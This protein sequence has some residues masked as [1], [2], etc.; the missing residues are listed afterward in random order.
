MSE[1]HEEAHTGPV[2]T[3]TQFLMMMVLSFIIPVFVII[4]LVYYI[5]S[6]HKPALGVS[7]PEEAIASRIQKV[8][9]VQIK[10]ANQPL[11]TGEA[12][13]AAQCAACHTSGAAGAPKLGDTAAWS[14]RNK[15][16]YPA[17]LNSALKGK[18][19]MAAQAGGEHGDLEIGRAV[20]Y[21]ANAAGAKFADPAPAEAK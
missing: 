10:D 9:A 8:G 20:V 6:D 19:A 4:G 13:Y 17:L 11:K 2:K 3:P 1:Q 14:P 16:G 18:N 15:T 12:V 7:N 5:T 21:M